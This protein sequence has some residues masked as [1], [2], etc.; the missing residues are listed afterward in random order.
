MSGPHTIDRRHFFGLAAGAALSGPLQVRVEQALLTGRGLGDINRRSAGPA[1][2]V[3]GPADCP[4]AAWARRLRAPLAAG[5]MQGGQLDVRYAGGVDGV[6]GANQFDARV[7]PDGQDALLFPGSVAMAW[8]ADDGRVQLDPAHMLP[9]AAVF[10]PGVLMV[11]GGLAADL[12][13]GRRAG[14]GARRGAA[15]PGGKLRLGV[16]P[17]PDPALTALLGLDLLGI[18]AT[19]V[20]AWPDPVAAARQGAADAVF[21]HGPNAALQAPALLADGFR[22]AL[23]TDRHGASADPALAAPYFL[24]GLPEARLRHDPL[25]DAWRAAA[26]ASMLCAVLVVPR[27][28]PAAAIGRWR[29][30]AAMTVADD[31]VR[32][33]A[34][35]E[36]MRLAAGSDA[37]GALAPMEVGGATQLALR[38]W[39]AQRVAWRP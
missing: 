7:V 37:V 13:P 39:M 36:A 34:D 26:A 11:Q 31:D 35:R 22:P 10:G 32:A 8:L 19:G 23:S 5:L 16:G 2:D 12:T 4:L 17:G 27:M 9:L 29:R 14:G 28:T 6:T 18:G 38:R 21:L 20:P 30:A 25:V 24:A 1:L 15:R 3:A 33:A